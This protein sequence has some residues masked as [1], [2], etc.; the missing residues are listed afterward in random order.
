MPA[1]SPDARCSEDLRGGVWGRGASA[2]GEGCSAGQHW[3]VG[4]AR[5]RPASHAQLRLG[6]PARPVTQLG[7]AARQPPVRPFISNCAAARTAQPCSVA[8]SLPP[9]A[10]PPCSRPPAHPPTPPVDGGLGG[11]HVGAAPT[12]TQFCAPAAARPPT[13]PATHPLMRNWAAATSA[14]LKSL[15]SSAS[16]RPCGYSSAWRGGQAGSIAWR[17]CGCSGAWRTGKA[18]QRQLAALL[19]QWCA[20]G[21]A[22]SVGAGQAA[23]AQAGSLAR[24]ARQQQTDPAAPPALTTHRGLPAP[25]RGAP[26]RDSARTARCAARRPAAQ[27]F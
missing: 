8:Q 25:P 27:S 13:H 4:A 1:L 3:A 24:S 20:E 5:A 17:L 21:R 23:R 14:R 19:A 11:R 10:L 26:R 18:G 16:W 15:D 9:R 7:P 12:G 2:A 22:G 6:G